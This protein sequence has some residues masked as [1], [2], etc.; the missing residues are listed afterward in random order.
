MPHVERMISWLSCL[1]CT[2]DIS[3]WIVKIKV[4]MTG[5]VDLSIPIS[6]NLWMSTLMLTCLLL[7]RLNP[8]HAEWI[9]MP[10]PL[11]VLANQITWSRLSKQIHILY[12]KQ[13]RSRSVGFRSQLIWIYTVCKCRSY[14]FS[15]TRLIHLVVFSYLFDFLFGFQHFN[16]LSKSA[17]LWIET[18]CS[19][20]GANSFLSEWPFFIREKETKIKYFASNFHW[21]CT[22]YPL[23]I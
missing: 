22:N 21:K 2:V 4:K 23:S 10:R 11:L 6:N 19:H 8:C 14:S 5:K 17:Q 13:C 18:N 16:R 20:K 15:R 3:W 9:K 1:N 12:D 7:K